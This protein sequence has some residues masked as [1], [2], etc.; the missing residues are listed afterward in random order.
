MAP[1]SRAQIEAALARPKYKVEINTSGT[2]WVHL[3]DDT[4]VDVTGALETT[5]SLD[6]GFSFGAYIAPRATVITTNDNMNYAWKRKRIRISFTFD[7]A[8]FVRA[9]T[10]VIRSRKREKNQL[11]FEC[12][13]F[14]YLISITKLYT[15]INYRIPVATKTSSTSIEDPSNVNY[16][17]GLINRIWW[18]AGG[19]P[20]EQISTYPSAIF[21]YSVP[22]QSITTPDWTWIGGEN[23]FDEI[24]KLVQASGGQIYQDPNGIMYYR[25]PL[26]PTTDSTPDVYTFN[27]SVFESISEDTFTDTEVASVTCNFVQ[28]FLQQQQEVYSDDTPRLILAGESEVFTLDMK[29]PV[30]TYELQGKALSAWPA[31]FKAVR[32]DA[33][34]ATP[35]VTA[36]SLASTRVIIT[37]KNNEDQPFTI[38]HTVINGRPITPGEQRIYTFGSGTPNLQIADS[39]YIQNEFH[40]Q[41]IT[42]MVYDF[43]NT[44]KPKI[45]LSG[46][47]YDP[48]R[49]VGEICALN[50]APWS[51]ELETYYRIISINISNAGMFAD[52]VLVGIEGVPSIGD[53]FTVGNSY[54]NSDVYKVGY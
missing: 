3:D 43:Y 25:Q 54:S 18:A 16:R 21:Y 47:G 34:P 15:G 48:D 8:D 19:R 5:N 32:Y 17:A 44:T 37:V 35:T 49:Y 33:L 51:D 24:I 28:R 36:I 20:Y 46:C 52:Y 38:T 26:L 4:I 53:F 2:T 27:S 9:F 23:S 50:Y 6:N 39:V 45:T 1:P 7:N 14:D 42:Q 30:Y 41:K 10:G 22:Y 11:T 29:D 12:V 13:G 40:A 31:I